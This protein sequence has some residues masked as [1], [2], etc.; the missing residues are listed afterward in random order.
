MNCPN[1]GFE[2]PLEMIFCGMCGTRL[3]TVCANCNF[4]NPD[5]FR[6]CGHCGAPLPLSERTATVAEPAV[7]YNVEP[8]T[9][10][11]A[12]PAA[13][14][15]PMLEGERRLATVLIADVKGSTNLLEQLGTEAWVD[16]MNRV[17]QTLEAEVYRFGGQVDQFRGDGLVAFWGA[18]LAHEDDP[19]RAILAALAMQRESQAFAAQLAEQQGVQLQLRI[20][21]NSGEV[22]VAQI[23]ERSQH[24]EDTA[25][26]EAIALAARMESSAEPGTVLVSENTFHLVQGQ[27]KWQPLGEIAVKGISAP[28]TV[29]RPIEPRAGILRSRRLHLYGLSSHLVGRREQ[30]EAI[31]ECI[32]KLYTGQGGVVML[33]GGEGTGKSELVSVVRSRVARDRAIVSKALGESDLLQV[34]PSPTWL[35][36]QCHSFEQTRPYAMWLDLLG[37][38]LG[39][40]EGECN[41]ASCDCLRERALA[42]WGD[43]MGEYY[44]YLAKFL[45]LPLPSDVAARVALLDA[46]GLRQRILLSLRKW[47]EAMIGQGPLILVFDD[48]HWADTSSLELLQNCLPLCEQHPLLLIVILRKDR[49][50]VVQPIC[51]LIEREFMHLLTDL[52]LLPLTPEQSGAMIDNLLGPNVLAADLRA[53]I[54]RKAEGN[55]YYIEEL[56]QML[57]RDGTLVRDE[58]TGHWLPT[59]TVDSLDLPDT[60]RGLL[61]ASMEGLSPDER[62]VLQVASVIGPIFWLNMLA[63]LLDDGVLLERHLIALQDAQLIRAGMS[64]PELGQEYTFQSNMLRETAYEGLLSPLRT[65]YH[66]KTGQYMEQFF[67]LDTSPRYYAFLAYHYHCAGIASKEL[68][69]ALQTAEHAQ[70]IYANE[71]AVDQY[72]RA[73]HLLDEMEAQARGETRLYVI[74]TQ[75]FEA[76]NGRRRVLFRLGRVVEGVADAQALLQLAGQLDDDPAWTIDALLQQ[77]GVAGWDSLEQL[78][79]GISMAERALTLA[80]QIDDQQRELMCLGAIANQLLSLDDPRSGQVAEAALQL[81]R[82]LKDRYAEVSILTGMGSVYMWSDQQARGVEF[83]QAAL[84][85]SQTS[86]D[87][88]GEISLLEMMGMQ[89]ERQGDYHRMLTE[90][91]EKRLQLAVELGHLPLQANALMHCGQ[92][93]G[94]YLGDYEGGL[95]RL[96]ESEQRWKM[97]AKNPF[98]LLR[99]IQVATEMDDTAAALSLVERARQLDARTIHDMGHAGM[100]LVEAR[101]YLALGDRAHLQQSLDLCAR[102][103]QLVVSRHF[104]SRQYQMAADC[105]SAA[106]YLK[107]AEPAEDDDVRQ[108]HHRQ[109]LERSQAALDLYAQLGGVQVIECVSE[110]ILFVHSRALLANEQDEQAGEFLGQAYDEMMRKHALIPA[111]SAYSQTF[112]ENIPLHREILLACQ[113]RLSISLPNA[114]Q[115]ARR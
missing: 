106:V 112:L 1:C 100:Y 95:A 48:V 71:E 83:L 38:W 24:S 67:G 28:V 42:L 98:V 21:I 27:F 57:I 108:A 72:T 31:R 3:K 73:L 59:R 29:Y 99:I 61:L 94:I 26:G 12:V 79:E 53:L 55:P 39:R 44:P 88:I 13:R 68:F 103:S 9:A 97:A 80:R 54:A 74:H 70:A 51:S 113:E 90:F 23:G 81:A 36:G 87:K 109:A 14:S 115:T 89:C 105:L 111:D 62:H 52:E 96:R 56:I 34:L 65:A 18:R 82:E 20:G 66:L 101:L 110:E 43:Q 30:F 6:F 10:Q 114:A 75:R 69:Y 86:N 11:D 50:A 2:S 76:L 35:F 17:L 22:I 40:G 78:R 46:E 32:D 58:Q 93:Q 64:T 92:I 77:P 15:I 37:D 41:T 84:E 102:T 16:L 47:L 91:H 5:T 45:D 60:V 104:L 8:V 63:H 25:M 33:T 19:E 7:V 49:A 4:A 85:L 107:L